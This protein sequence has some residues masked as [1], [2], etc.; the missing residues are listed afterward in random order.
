MLFFIPIR[1]R[2]A[3]T[4]ILVSLVITAANSLVSKWIHAAHQTAAMLYWSSALNIGS[5][6]YGIWDPGAVLSNSK[7]KDI[8]EVAIICL[9]G[10]FP[11]A[12][13]H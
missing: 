5:H 1:G 6:M 12:L 2:A 9:E 8:S 13:T 3:L 7:S 4:Q 11:H 10:F